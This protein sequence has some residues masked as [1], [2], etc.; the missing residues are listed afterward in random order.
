MAISAAGFVLEYRGG[1]EDI[2]RYADAVLPQFSG[3]VKSNVE[4]IAANRGSTGVIGLVV[5]LWSGTAVFDAIEFAMNKVWKVPVGRHIILSKLL[6]ISGVVVVIMLLLLATVVSAGFDAFEDYW[7]TVFKTPPPIA[8]AAAMVRI[9][10]LVVTLSALL[11]IYSVVPNRRLGLGDVWV[12]AG[13][14]TA[15]LYL[16]KRA[17][18]VYTTKAARFNAVY[19]SVGVI[20]GLLFWLY[21]T[22]V[23]LVLGAEI[24]AALAARRQNRDRSAGFQGWAR[25]GH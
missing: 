20:I 10:G 15:A 3:I 13:F 14:S 16:A 18:V 5:L 23:I 1:Y 22:G 17:F 21:I 19:G 7:L 25:N 24:N 12:G 4:S 6:S 9:V 11:I 2:L 8:A